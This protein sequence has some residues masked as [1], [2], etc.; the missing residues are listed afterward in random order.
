MT[1]RISAFKRYTGKE[2]L[3]DSEMNVKLKR[4][5]TKVKQKQMMLWVSKEKMFSVKE[6][7]ICMLHR[8]LKKNQFICELVCHL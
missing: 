6:F 5:K 7:S 1:K 3:K 2:E 8:G 4:G